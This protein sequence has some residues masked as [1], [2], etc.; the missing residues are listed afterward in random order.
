MLASARMITHCNRIATKHAAVVTTGILNVS[1]GSVNTIAGHVRFTLDVRAPQDSTVAAVER[2]LKRDF[3]A[4]ATGENVGG[5]LDGATVG[6]AVSVSWQ[7]DSESAATMFDQQ[8]VEIVRASAKVLTGDDGLLR[9]MTS[10]AGHDSVHTSL[11]CPTAM[12]FVPSKDGISHNPVEYTSPEDCTIGASVL[13]QCVLRF[14]EARARG[15][16]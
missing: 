5:L 8:C 6:R 3:A 15:G 10:G 11:H 14:D 1:P 13:L 2:E 9:D 16:V 12:V 7:T 4:L